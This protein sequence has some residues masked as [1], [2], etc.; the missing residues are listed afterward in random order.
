MSSTSVYT[1]NLPNWIKQTFENFGGIKTETLTL[2][3]LLDISKL[4]KIE[5]L[6]IY[7]QFV[8]DHEQIL[9]NLL[10]QGCVESLTIFNY[11]PFKLSDECMMRLDGL[12]KTQTV[13]IIVNG[14][15]VKKYENMNI[16]NQ[17]VVEHSISHYFTLLLSNIL[18]KKRNPSSIF[19]LQTV[20][21]D[22]FRRTVGNF[23]QNSSIAKNILQLPPMA[24]KGLYNLSADFIKKVE[25]EHGPGQHIHALQS[26]GNG[27]PNFKTYESA[28]CEIVLETRNSGHWHFTE[29][30]FRPIVMCIPMVHL[31][32]GPMY[33]RLLEYG[34]RFYDY[35][36]YETWHS[37]MPLENKLPCLENFLSHI[38]DNVS[39]QKQMEEIAEHN[40]KHFWNE[41]KLYY[42]KNID[43]AFENIFGANRSINKIYDQLNF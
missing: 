41:R 18:K 40:Y 34:Y 13:N 12:A 16:Y 28:F 15:Y 19:A 17:E 7:E 21:K 30:T 27:L 31:G 8:L 24:S 11:H 9:V 38:R 26:F 14:H 35:N 2:S 22:D 10:E 25:V 20:F 6:I 36:F 37:D 5:H 29:K 32:H 3:Q 39:S 43:D 4:R 23:I 1:V 42:Y 33:N